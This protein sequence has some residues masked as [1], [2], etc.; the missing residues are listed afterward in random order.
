MFYV[1]VLIADGLRP[2]PTNA[3]ITKLQCANFKERCLYYSG[4]HCSSS[5]SSSNS[6]A[7]ISIFNL[8]KE[9]CRQLESP[10]GK[11][12]DFICLP[13]SPHENGEFIMIHLHV[14]DAGGLL[15]FAEVQQPFA[16]AVLTENKLAMV[17]VQSHE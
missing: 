5:A 1:F 8:K 15:S 11:V 14:Q 3:S 7:L 4:G 17:D 6:G 16:L 9:S 2:N 12:I 13:T 10:D